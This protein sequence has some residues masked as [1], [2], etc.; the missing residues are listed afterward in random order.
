MSPQKIYIYIHI[1]ICI[2][3]YIRSFI[4]IGETTHWSDHFKFF[5]AVT[6]WLTSA[7]RLDDLDVEFTRLESDLWYH[8]TTWWRTILSSRYGLLVKSQGG[9]GPAQGNKKRNPTNSFF[10]HRLYGQNHELELSIVCWSRSFLFKA[11]FLTSK[12]VGY[13][14]FCRRRLWSNFPS[15]QDLTSYFCIYLSNLQAFVTKLP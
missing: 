2:Y 14:W 11:L 6:S 8:L 12:T 15:P 4:S 5:L 3:I 9:H 7:P 13:F 1:P 10:A